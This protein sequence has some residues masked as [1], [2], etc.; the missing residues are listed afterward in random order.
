MVASVPILLER[1]MVLAMR[2]DGEMTSYLRSPVL[3]LSSRPFFVSARL[4]LT[5]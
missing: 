4:S 5:C 3:G 2:L 1:W